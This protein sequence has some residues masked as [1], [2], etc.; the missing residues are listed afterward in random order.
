M[1]SVQFLGFEPLFG[2]LIRT[3][4]RYDVA[5]VTIKMENKVWI[6]RLEAIVLLKSN[7]FLT[8]GIS[9]ATSSQE[10]VFVSF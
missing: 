3:F 9:K 7:Q 2:S 6:A 10:K 8:L 1:T 4:L 5:N